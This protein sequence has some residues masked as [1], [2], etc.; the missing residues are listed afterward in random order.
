MIGD[1]LYREY[2]TWLKARVQDSGCHYNIQRDAAC[3]T[4]RVKIVNMTKDPEFKNVAVVEIY[5]AY[6]KTHMEILHELNAAFNERQDK[7][8]AFEP[9]EGS[10]S[11]WGIHA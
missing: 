9:A 4:A 8:S 6:G 5:P 2:E 7:P 3:D 10:F 1:H 11:H